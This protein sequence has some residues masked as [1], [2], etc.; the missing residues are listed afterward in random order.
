M[1][2]TRGSSRSISTLQYHGV[3]APGYPHYFGP[4]ARVLLVPHPAGSVRLGAAELRRRVCGSRGASREPH[5]SS[6][7]RRPA[8]QSE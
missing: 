5:V 7:L 3:R 8:A 4:Y 2:R 6:T 1:G